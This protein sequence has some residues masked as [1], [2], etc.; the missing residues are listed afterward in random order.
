MV[1]TALLEGSVVSS[2]EAQIP[3]S[4]FWQFISVV[5]EYETPAMPL[6]VDYWLT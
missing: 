3:H 5:W 2:K 4:T 6:P 1:Q